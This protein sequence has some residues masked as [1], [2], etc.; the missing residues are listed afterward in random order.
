[1]GP[2]DPVSPVVVGSTYTVATVGAAVPAAI[3]EPPPLEICTFSE[4]RSSLAV[5]YFSVAA[6]LRLVC[7]ATASSAV[8]LAASFFE[9]RLL[10]SSDVQGVARGVAIANK[11]VIRGVTPAGLFVKVLVMSSI[12]V[13]TEVQVVGTG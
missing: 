3:V 10:M 6:A 11:A 9:L 1:V 4:M 7:F 2:V 8:D 5:L 13:S 12:N